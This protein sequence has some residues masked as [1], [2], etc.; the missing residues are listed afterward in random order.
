MRYELGGDSGTGS[1]GPAALYKADVL[2]A[3]VASNGIRDVIE[4]G[5]GDGRQLA[6]ARYPSYR[7][8][9]ISPDVVKRCSEQFRGDSRKSFAL[10]DG[11][12]ERADLA[13]SLDVIFHLVEDEIYFTH[14]DQLFAAARRFVVIYATD[15][16]EATHSFAHVRHRHVSEDVRRRFPSFA[17]MP[18]LPSSMPAPVEPSSGIQAIFMAYQR[19]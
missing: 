18:P 7:G 5:C 16:A 6:L 19:R 9:D 11:N 4:F 1:A 14:L 2:N 12:I 13:L 17:M 8:L 15:S 10:V 3:F